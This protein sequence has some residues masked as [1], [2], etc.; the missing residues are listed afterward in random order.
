MSHKFRPIISHVLQGR[1]SPWNS[2]QLPELDLLRVRGIEVSKRLFCITDK[3]LP[4]TIRLDYYAG[5]EKFIFT[6]NIWTWVPI[7]YETLVFRYANRN[8]AEKDAELIHRRLEMLR[9]KFKQ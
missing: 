6:G 7:E 4:W 8:I 1:A 9:E 2:I 3:K 5:T